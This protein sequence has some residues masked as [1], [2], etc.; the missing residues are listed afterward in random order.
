MKKRYSYN[1]IDD[2]DEEYEGGSI[3]ADNITEALKLIAQEDVSEYIDMEDLEKITV[4]IDNKVYDIDIS[5]FLDI[6]INE[7][8]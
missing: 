3:K 6:K 2:N 7:R 8:T 4:K 1:Y 5:L